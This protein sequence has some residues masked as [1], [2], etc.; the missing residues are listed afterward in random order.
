MNH[1][2]EVHEIFSF[3][4]YQGNLGMNLHGNIYPYQ[5]HCL[6]PDGEIV[7]SNLF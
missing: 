6:D 3:N 2:T 1:F 5:A 7:G 4:I